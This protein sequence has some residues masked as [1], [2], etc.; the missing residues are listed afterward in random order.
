M[1]YVA[2]LI[3]IFSSYYVYS[4]YLTEEREIDI[5]TLFNELSNGQ[6]VTID[7]LTIASKKFA[8]KLCDDEIYQAERHHTLSSCFQ[9]YD[10]FEER[11]VNAIFTNK[12]II[13]SK[14]EADQLFNRFHRCVVP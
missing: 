4:Q 14:K 3:I 5:K 11:C 1:K 9:Q 6:E 10:T 13:T 2:I 7:E 12:K 8:L